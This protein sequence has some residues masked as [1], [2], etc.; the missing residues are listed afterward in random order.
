MGLDGAAPVVR[1]LTGHNIETNV[2]AILSR[3]C[4]LLI[5]DPKLLMLVR[6]GPDGVGEGCLHAST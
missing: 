1:R 6:P 3:R 5:V 4:T 2:V